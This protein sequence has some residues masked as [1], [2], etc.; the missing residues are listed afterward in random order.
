MMENGNNGSANGQ[1]GGSDFLRVEGVVKNFGAV[2]VLK[3]VDMH[4]KRGEVLGLIGDNGAGKSTLLKTI[5]GFHRPDGGR[6]LIE[7]QEVNLRSVSQ[8][9]ALGIETVYQDLA[10]VNELSVFHNMFLNSEMTVGPFLN[11]RKMKEHTRRY[12]EDMGV[13][14]PSIDT[15]VARL[16]GGQRQAIAVA[17]AVYSDAKMLLLDEPLAAMG[18]K[19]GALILD[20]IQRIKDERGIPMILIVH[21]YAQV[22]DVC[23]R[24]NLI[25]NGRIEY[26]KP[27]AE[28]SVEE[29]TELVVSEY[30]KARETGHGRG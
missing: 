26:D 28:S 5:T 18:A 20:L 30:R 10:L 24:V 19:E 27:V 22:F 7:G 6:I 29:L 8:A 16:S 2:S 4:V 25:R 15:E 17:R 21:N 3:G 9:R 11:N 13:S 23:D 14:I 12:L 1:A